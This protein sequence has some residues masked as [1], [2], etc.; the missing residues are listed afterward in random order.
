M[1]GKEHSFS[2]NQPFPYNQWAWKGDGTFCADVEMTA[3]DTFFTTAGI[4]HN[5][6]ESRLG[7]H[8]RMEYMVVERQLSMI[9]DPA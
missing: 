6:L 1:I 5:V 7:R 4:P 2:A 9:L 8:Y 3:G